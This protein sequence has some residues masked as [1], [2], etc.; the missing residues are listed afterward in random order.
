MNRSRALI[1]AMFTVTLVAMIVIATSVFLVSVGK[2]HFTSGTDLSVYADSAN[3]QKATI[4]ATRGYIFD[5]NG[6]II[7]QDVQTYN[8][9]CVLDRNRPSIEGTIAYV[10]DP[11]YTAQI[12]SQCL[13][14]DYQTCLDFLKQDKYQTELGLPGR[15]IT[16]DVKE[17]IESYNLPGVEFTSSI[18]RS[19]PLGV[20]APYLV[21]FAQSNEEGSSTGKMGVEQY[22]ET[23]LHGED[24][25][26]MY[27]ADKNGYKL[28]GM[29]ET[30]VSAINGNNVYLTL[31][32]EIQE[33]LEQAF[34]LSNE[35]FELDRVWGAVMEIDTG[36]ILAWGQYP[37]FNPNTLDIEDYNNY[38]AQL[39]YE[40][41]STM[42]PFLYA[43]AIE[44]G[45][46]DSETQ[47]DTGPFCYTWDE[48][49]NPKRTYGR[50]QGCITNASNKSWGT[51]SMDYGLIYSSNVIA[52]T[53]ETELLNPDLYLDYLRKFGFFQSVSTDG[54]REE[55]G[56]LNFTWPSDKLAL[57]YGQGSTVTMLQMMQGYSALLSDGTMKRPY[58]IDRIVDSYDENNVIYQAETQ[59]VGSPISEDTAKQLQG[60]MWHVVNDDDGTAKYYQIPETEIIGKTGTTQVAV[61]GTYNSG[62]TIASFV[63]GMP[64]D[65]PKYMV[66]Y[67]W[68]AAYNKNAHYY[69]EPVKTV[70]R[71]VA[72]TYGLTQTVD[73]Q[74]NE[75]EEYVRK[76]IKTYDMMNLTN[77]TLDYALEQ[78]SWMDVDIMI[79][80]DGNSVIDQFPNEGSVVKTD[81]KV[82]LLTDTTSFTMPDMTGWSR[83]EV[84]SLWKITGNDFKLSG[85][86]KVKSQN[87]VPGTMVSKSDKIEVEF[88]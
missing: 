2:V 83:K 28:P 42:K 84:V 12:L 31:D 1:R 48:N 55:V 72:M 88:E 45:V 27:Q 54:M 24:G 33:T 68:E 23:Y 34:L 82:F 7:A 67:C 76:D 79:V 38:G 40:P 60:I 36:R 3:M 59:I 15:N 64:A 78:L 44:E 58:Y 74:A 18:Q 49:R 85:Y 53:V 25:Y 63:C 8:I 62:K 20:F 86:G 70:L 47:V 39:P 61:S 5:K 80:G 21:G 26:R 73:E 17:L 51:K 4:R 75:D 81:Q 69:S 65:D 22:L 30:L 77:H 19:Y 41:G 9:Y 66:Y 43:A 56:I 52:A 32:K 46:Y 57:A 11:E 10:D 37:S 13:K 29:K 71:K 16:K 6:N 50:S 35:Q 87:I 14:M